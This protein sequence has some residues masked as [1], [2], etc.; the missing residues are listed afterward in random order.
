MN[1]T[2]HRPYGT[3]TVSRQR[4]ESRSFLRRR[5][6]ARESVRE[7]GRGKASGRIDGTLVRLDN[8]LLSGTICFCTVGSTPTESCRSRVGWVVDWRVRIYS[9]RL[10]SSLGSGLMVGSVSIWI[11]YKY[12]KIRWFKPPPNNVSFSG[13]TWTKSFIVLVEFSVLCPTIPHRRLKT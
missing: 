7:R 11:T 13:R 10:Y 9:G 12:N 3:C 2:G 4:F 8:L 5:E 1:E 6:R